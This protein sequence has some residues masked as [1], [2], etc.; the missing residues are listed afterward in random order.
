[1]RAGQ[2]RPVERS[3]PITAGLPKHDQPLNVGHLPPICG[4]TLEKCRVAESDSHQRSGVNIALSNFSLWFCL[5]E[6][7]HVGTGVG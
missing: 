5:R 1:M 3:T 7:S 6:F 2:Q 4:A